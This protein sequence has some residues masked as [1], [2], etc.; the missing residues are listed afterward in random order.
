MDNT[1]NIIDLSGIREP[2]NTAYQ[3]AY[4]MPKL[5][6]LDVMSNTVYTFKLAK[7]YSNNPNHIYVIEGSSPNDRYL[8]KINPMGQFFG[9]GEYYKQCLDSLIRVS[10][11]MS[12]ATISYGRVWNKCGV[13]NRTLK[14]KIS[15]LAG[16]GPICA[17]RYG[18]KM[19]DND[20]NIINE[21]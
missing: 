9:C 10:S 19:Y 5:K 18:W 11:N 6:T 7:E 1:D 2:F 12:E 13:C 3:N 16:I 14:T 15:C 20:G 4:M 8:G 21:V 17:S